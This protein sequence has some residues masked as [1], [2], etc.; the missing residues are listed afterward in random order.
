MRREIGVGLHGRDGRVEFERLRS[1]ARFG[2][3]EVDPGYKIVVDSTNNTLETGAN[4]TVIVDMAVR[5]SP[6]AAL[7]KVE[8]VK[9]ALNG[10]L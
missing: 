3:E 5:L 10:A 6:T 4:N 9:V 8:I 7:I 2:D 1:A